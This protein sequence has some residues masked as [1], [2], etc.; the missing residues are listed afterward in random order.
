M[1]VHSGKTRKNLFFRPG[2]K[3]VSILVG[4]NTDSVFI[5][6]PKKI[7]IKNY[8]QYKNEGWKPKKYHSDELNEEKP[9][10]TIAKNNEWNKIDDNDK[11]SL[12][13]QSC[14][15]TGA[16]YNVEINTAKIR[17]HLHDDQ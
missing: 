10:I 12:K 14:L 15:V 1:S 8:P 11:E 6:N 9:T 3:S 7:D 17:I 2:L 4:Y 16:N 5:K 13:K